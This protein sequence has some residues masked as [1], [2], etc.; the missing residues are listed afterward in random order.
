MSKRNELKR[1]HFLLLIAVIVVAMFVAGT[2]AGFSNQIV[3]T[4]DVTGK[5]TNVNYD[6]VSTIVYL[7]DG[8]V[9]Y[10]PNRL[11]QNLKIGKTYCFHFGRYRF[12]T[13]FMLLEHEEI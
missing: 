7:E 11:L 6:R 3:E 9:L 8:T 4:Y 2:V 13:N 5:V 12:G 1:S 10:I